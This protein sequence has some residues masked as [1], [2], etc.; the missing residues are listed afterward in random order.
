MKCTVPS[1]FFYTAG[2]TKMPFQLR[3]V[4]GAEGRDYQRQWR[5]LFLVASGQNGAQHFTVVLHSDVFNGK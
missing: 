3:L 1:V 5:L 2:F 4:L